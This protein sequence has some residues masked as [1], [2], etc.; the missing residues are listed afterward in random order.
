[1]EEKVKQRITGILVLIGAL[2]IIVPFLFYNTQTPPAQKDQ[3]AVPNPMNPPSVALKLP[4]QNGA[5]Q[6]SM[7]PNQI[8]PA[9]DAVVARQHDATSVQ[10]QSVGQ[11]V[12]VLDESKQ[13]SSKE[14][15]EAIVVN[16]L[17]S[18][19]VISDDVAQKTQPKP[20]NASVSSVISVTAAKPM[21]SPV[22]AAP[23]VSRPS[24]VRVPSPRPAQLTVNSVVEQSDKVKTPV[25][26]PVFVKTPVKS[27]VVKVK[28]QV[29]P[30]VPQKAAQVKS[31]PYAVAVVSRG[32]WA[33]QMGVF[34]N[35][36]NA[37]QLIAK[38]HAHHVVAYSRSFKLR[39]RY[40]TAVMVGQEA[41]HAKAQALKNHLHRKLHLRGVVKKVR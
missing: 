20:N 33:V 6:V 3:S 14:S 17:T 35:A 21:R 13:K 9:E 30:S 15:S 25:V 7:Q 8:Q 11:D 24:A 1:M 2:L 40:V 12:S 28:Q 29:A 5:D 34:S 16:N 4:G 32:G 39:G 23:S 18:H 31:K 41:T 27:S 26:K 10:S 36:S 19:A 37:K 22:T 38:L